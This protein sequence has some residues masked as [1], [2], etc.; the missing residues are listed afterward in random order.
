MAPGME[1]EVAVRAHDIPH[2]WP[3][4]VSREAAQF[5]PEVPA[6]AVQGRVDLRD[7]PLVTIDGEDARD[8][9]DAVFAEYSGNSWRLIVAIADVSYYVKPATALDKEA[10]ARGNS[11]YFPQHVV[12]M[13]PEALSNGLCSINPARRPLVHG[14]R[15]ENRRPRKNQPIPFSRSGH[16]LAGAPHLH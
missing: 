13:L 14:L 2:V 5:A 15:D 4:E 7:L 16:A 1:I 3:E 8:F 12:P 11:V 10:Y 9:D 6:Q